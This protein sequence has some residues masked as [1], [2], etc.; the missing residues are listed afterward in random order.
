M[1]SSDVVTHLFYKG[2]FHLQRTSDFVQARQE[3][4]L[5]YA[6]CHRASLNRARILLLLIP[7]Q[8]MLGVLP[9]LKALPDALAVRFAP[10]VEALRK[11]DLRLFGAAL[12]HYHNDFVNCGILLLLQK[13]DLLVLRSLV[14]KVYAARQ[15]TTQ[16]PHIVPLALIAKAM[17][18]RNAMY[19]KSEWRRM[20]GAGEEEE[21]VWD[22][23]QI[24][25]MLA[26][27]VFKKLVK[28]YIAHQNAIVLSTKC[29]FPHVKEVHG[30]W[31]SDF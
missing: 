6:L 18:L 17:A 21:E 15:R 12:M 22:V 13:L 23:D 9:N 25:C 7:I 5:A 2:R 14:R 19:V 1:I 16:K 11:G 24:E 8:M 20:F 29:A 30:W 31:K 26:M 4:S 28:G 27:L 10:I 3:L